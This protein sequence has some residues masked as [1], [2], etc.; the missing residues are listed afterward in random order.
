MEQCNAVR[1][2]A[3]QGSANLYGYDHEDDPRD[4]NPG[5]EC[6][7]WA[8]LCYLLPSRD[9]EDEKGGAAQGYATEAAQGCATENGGLLAP[10]GG[11]LASLRE[12]SRLDPE[13]AQ[14]DATEDGGLL[15]PLPEQSKAYPEAVK[16]DAT[17]DGGLLAPLREQSKAYPEAAQ[18][19]ATKDGGLLAPRT[20]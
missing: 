6:K 14:G 17:E 10:H 2:A 15:A 13:A 16:G 12:Q 4:P 9:E 8:Y 11:L 5:D 7:P 18:G 3:R 1:K 20:P 19:D